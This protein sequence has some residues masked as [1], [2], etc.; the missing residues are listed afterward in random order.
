MAWIVW[1]SLGA[2]VLG[3]LAVSWWFDRD[4]RRRGAAVR[5]SGEM[6]TA[7][8]RR[9]WEVTRETSQQSSF[10]GTPRVQDQLRAEWRGRSQR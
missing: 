2:V 10:G 5:S 9:R 6:W 4:A 8:R 3:S 1:G 7:A